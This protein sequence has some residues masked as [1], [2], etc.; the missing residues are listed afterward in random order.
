M[1]INDVALYGII[2]SCAILAYL[3][4]LAHQE[5]KRLLKSLHTVKERLNKLERLVSDVDKVEHEM[6]NAAI[7][8]VD[9]KNLDLIMRETLEFLNDR[10]PKRG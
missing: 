10:S 9:K 8:K 6:H 1:N 2:I 3:A 4:Y 5:Q 7:E